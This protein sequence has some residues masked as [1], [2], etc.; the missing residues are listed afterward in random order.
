MPY[1]RAVF[2][3]AT[4][5]QR[6]SDIMTAVTEVWENSCR[7]ITTGKLNQLFLD[8]VAVNPIRA[9]VKYVTQVGVNPPTFAVFVSKKQFLPPTYER[10]LENCLRKAVDF[11]G[12]PIKIYIREN[13]DKRGNKDE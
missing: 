11:A 4:T 13:V 1:F 3:S 7:R 8:F 10:Y 5:G 12:T 2:T 6:L 9:K